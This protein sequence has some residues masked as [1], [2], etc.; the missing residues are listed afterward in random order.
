VIELAA[1]FEATVDQLNF[2]DGDEVKV[3]DVVIVLNC[4]KML[5][6]IHAPYSGVVHY[7]VKQDD[8]VQEGEILLKIE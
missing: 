7:N 8:Y 2:K 6:H 5:M 4:M 1:E 3:G